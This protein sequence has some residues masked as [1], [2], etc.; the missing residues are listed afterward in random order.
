ME[1]PAKEGILYMQGAK[2]GMKSWRKMWVILFAASPYGIGRV[3]LYDV[4]DGGSG[5]VGMAGKQY[6]KKADK[7]VIRLADCISITPAP[8]ESCP[9]DNAA[10]Y[11]NTTQRTYALASEHAQAWIAKLCQLA[12]KRNDE[13]PTPMSSQDCGEVPMEENELYSSWKEE[14]EYE[15]TVQKTEASMRCSLTGN[16]TMALDKDSIVLL[17]PQ[18]RHTLYC[19]PYRLLRR[20]GQDKDVVSFEAGRRCES[21][22]GH[23]TFLSK[24]VQRI[25]KTIEDAI[26]Q[27]RKQMSRA[28]PDLD[29]V[30]LQP[31]A[32]NCSAQDLA[33]GRS[34]PPTWRGRTNEPTGEAPE[35]APVLLQK[36]IRNP[37]EPNRN[38]KPIPQGGSN[39]ESTHE[40]PVYSTVQVPFKKDLDRRAIERQKS[41]PSFAAIVDEKEEEEEEEKP[42]EGADE[43]EEP[44]EES[45]GEGSEEEEPDEEEERFFS[46]PESFNIDNWAEETSSSPLY[47]N[48]VKV[49]KTREQPEAKHRDGAPG[50]ESHYA[51]ASFN[52]R[53]EEEGVGEGETGTSSGPRSTIV[54]NTEIPNDFKQ[55][56]SD[57]FA[58]D[59]VKVLP[60]LP[61]RNTGITE[62]MYN[63]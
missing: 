36:P 47:D 30:S 60:A 31:S 53:P 3:E 41:F 42:E 20:F 16:Y 5:A 7:K 38:M 23:F 37:T 9:K 24:D 27:Q 12:F 49:N 10:F 21:G 45:E 14:K 40:S 32:H 55:K 51:L 4:R 11:L 61:T 52:R 50:S 28:I 44:E 62:R 22:E 6:L 26:G 57:L 34:A 19:W 63:N 29:T 2:F 18:S 33:P 13:N 17:D 46:V 43:G 54:T 56:L 48:I 15:V 39:V 35:R 1:N 8:G 25:Y 58:K 59:R